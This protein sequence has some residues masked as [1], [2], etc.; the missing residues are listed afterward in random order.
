VSKDDFIARAKEYGYDAEG[1]QGLLDVY[2]EMKE[3]DPSV[4]YEDVILV[5]QAVF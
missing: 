5:P 3:F 1:I 4:T 2:R